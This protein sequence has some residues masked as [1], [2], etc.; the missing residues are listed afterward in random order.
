MS[1]LSLVKSY[2]G[3]RGA[4]CPDMTWEPKQAFSA[5]AAF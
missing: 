1:A 2:T 5:V 3:Q 4:I